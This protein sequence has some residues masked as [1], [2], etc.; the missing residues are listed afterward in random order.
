MASDEESARPYGPALHASAHHGAPWPARPYGPGLRNQPLNLD[1][2]RDAGFAF[3][4][5]WFDVYREFRF[6]K[7][8]ELA[9]EGLR[10]ELRSAL[11]PW[12]VLGEQPVGPATSRL[13]D[14]SLNRIE[15][16][17]SGLV[18]PR[19]AVACN[20]RRVP[21]TPTGP[22]GEFVAGVRFRAWKPPECL[23]PT[24]PVHAPLVFDVLDLWSRRSVAGCTWHVAHPGGRS[25]ET[26]PVNA[27][28]A[29]SRR[30]SRF[31]ASGHTPGP[32]E[33]PPEETNPAYPVTLDLRRRG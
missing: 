13:V 18:H 14:A 27:L 19:Y 31:F 30:V 12:H 9:H 33:P 17:V 32:L 6:P 5:A 11:E 8:G 26:R 23:H 22:P 15:V 29:E 2:L 28:E 20:G 16:L 21:L 25:Y 10:L 3:E 24:I 7:L 4:D 1:D